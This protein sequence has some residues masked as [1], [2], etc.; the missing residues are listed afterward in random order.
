M[1][2]QHICT[3]H[4]SKHFIFLLLQQIFHQ[5]L[6]KHSSSGLLSVAHLIWVTVTGKDPV[7]IEKPTA[8]CQ[9]THC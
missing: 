7:T 2:K 3:F 5:C 6:V 8:E 9:V 1:L 4:L